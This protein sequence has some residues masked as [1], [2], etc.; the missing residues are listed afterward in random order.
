M[1]MYEHLIFNFDQKSF[2]YFN[3]FRRIFCCDA[4][5]EKTKMKVALFIGLWLNFEKLICS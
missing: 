2:P 4:F 3:K 5:C 1:V